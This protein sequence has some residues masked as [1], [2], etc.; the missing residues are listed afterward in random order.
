M[1]S[2]YF[3]FNIIW[4]EL[5]GSTME[6]ARLTGHEPSDTSSAGKTSVVWDLQV[7]YCQGM[8]IKCRMAKLMS[9]VKERA[10][11]NNL[12]NQFKNKIPFFM[13]ESNDF[14][15]DGAVIR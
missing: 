8:N 5:K 11:F 1:S 9:D 13:K 10:N 7:Q 12:N 3:L 2:V 4:P 14:E 6:M 15:V